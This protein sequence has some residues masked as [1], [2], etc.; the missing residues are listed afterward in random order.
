MSPE[1]A[2][3][4]VPAGLATELAS[5]LPAASTMTR[6]SMYQDQAPLALRVISSPATW[7]NCSARA[8]GARNW[9]IIA[10]RIGRDILADQRDE[11]GIISGSWFAMEIAGWAN[12]GFVLRLH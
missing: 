5:S 11:T 8:E 12:S 2:G 10:A 3:P 4:L 7:L 9:A 1:R 6:S